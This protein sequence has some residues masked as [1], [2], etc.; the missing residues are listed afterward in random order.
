MGDTPHSFH[1]HM[2][3]RMTRDE[4]VAAFGGVY[5][6]SAWIAGAVWDRG[7]DSRHDTAAALAAEMRDVVELAG[8][9]P[10]RALLR[11]HPDLAGKLAVAGKLTGESG[12]EQSSAGLDQCT[13]DEFAEFQRLNE[14]YGARFGFPFILAVSGYRRVEILENFR[15]RVDNDS[16]AE[17][18]E[19]LHQVHRIA[20]IRLTQID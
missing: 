17:F 1:T 13:E 15:A 2:P 14:A 19:A 9:E 5:E 8:R 16:D 10:Q 20:A 3:S 12:S 7:L 6:Y 4:F 11:A 18:E